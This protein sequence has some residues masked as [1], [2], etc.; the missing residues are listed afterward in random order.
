MKR[1]GS[2]NCADTTHGKLNRRNFLE[3][4]VTAAAFGM[5]GWTQSADAVMMQTYLAGG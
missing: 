1:N 2:S 3:A 4:G 5:L